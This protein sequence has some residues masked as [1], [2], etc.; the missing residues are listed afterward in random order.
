MCGHDDIAALAAPREIIRMP[1]TLPVAIHEAGT[2]LTRFAVRTQGPTVMSCLEMSTTGSAK[3]RAAMQRLK[4]FSFNPKFRD[5]NPSWSTNE[6]GHV[7]KYLGAILDTDTLE[8]IELDLEAYSVSNE[9]PMK[10]FGSLLAAR[11]WPKLQRCTILGL[12]IWSEDFKGFMEQIRRDTLSRLS[13]SDCYLQD[14]TWAEILDMLRSKASR[15]WGLRWMVVSWMINSSRRR[16]LKRFSV[17]TPNATTLL[18]WRNNTFMA[19][20]TGIHYE[21]ASTTTDLHRKQ[22][23]ER[24]GSRGSKEKKCP[25]QT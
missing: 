21:I 12:N 8:E 15:H 23:A 1:I 18:A 20:L 6:I 7:Q 3:L 11:P 5:A 10:R 16:R 22:R 9:D 17:I 13:F 25:S 2:W 4:V 24:L 14:E 19:K